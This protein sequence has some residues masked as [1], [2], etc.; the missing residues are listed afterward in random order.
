[1]NI[2]SNAV[3]TEKGLALLAKLTQGNTLEITNAITGTGFVTPG[4]LVKQTELTSP[5]Q[6]LKARPV[7]YPDIGR[8]DLPLVLTNEG[9]ASGYECTQVGVF[10]KDPDEGEILFFIAQSIAEDSGTTVPSEAEMPGYSAEWTFCLQYGQADNVT[11]TVDPANTVSRSEMIQFIDEEF[12][13]ITF[14]QIDA[15]AGIY[16]GDDTEIGG[17]TSGGTGSGGVG[18]LDH[19]ILLNRNIADQHTI[20]SITGLEA[21]LSEAGG[22]V[23]ASADIETVWNNA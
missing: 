4:L 8:C 11:V 19:S 21:A 10:A 7:S 2:W 5:K 3:I 6:T 14:A 17:G 1:M 15:L 18:T 23:L 16:G 22:T 13:P 12:V 9:L 20:E